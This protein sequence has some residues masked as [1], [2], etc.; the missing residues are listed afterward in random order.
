[1]RV[2]ETMMVRSHT[3]SPIGTPH[4]SFYTYTYTYTYSILYIHIFHPIHI[5]ISHLYIYVSIYLILYISYL[6]IYT[7]LFVYT[8]TPILIYSSFPIPFTPH[9]L[10]PTNRQIS[11]FLPLSLL[12]N[13]YTSYLIPP[14]VEE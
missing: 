13:L 2:T 10:L 5:H 1:M 11:N 6:Y 8:Y 12:P 7:Y 14:I 9:P 3:M 4:I